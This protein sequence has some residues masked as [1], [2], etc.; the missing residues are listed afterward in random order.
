MSDYLTEHL[1]RDL[2]AT[3]IVESTLWKLHEWSE[4]L[5]EKRER[6]NDKDLVG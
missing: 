4:M 2:I 5:E 3:L 6:M 1:T